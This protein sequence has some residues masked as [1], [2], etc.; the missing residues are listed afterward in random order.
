MAAN[1]AKKSAAASRKGTWEGGGRGSS[2]APPSP[3]VAQ[4]RTRT[5][6]GP[7]RDTHARGVVG[8]GGG[9]PEEVTHTQGSPSATRTHRCTAAAAAGGRDLTVPAA[10]KPPSLLYAPRRAGQSAAGGAA[11]SRV[12]RPS[13]ASDEPAGGVCASVTYMRP[14][15][16]LRVRAGGETPRDRGRRL[17]MTNT[18]RRRQFTWILVHTPHLRRLDLELVLESGSTENLQPSDSIRPGVSW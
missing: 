9:R 10:A 14:R 17:T 6:D 11:R 3:C 2:R 18:L 15:L 16:G 7:C 5:R 1:A 8:G 12:R 13:S 4:A